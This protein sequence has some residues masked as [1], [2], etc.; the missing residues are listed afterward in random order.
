MARPRKKAVRPEYQPEPPKVDPEIGENIKRQVLETL[1]KPKDHD[2]TIVN[3]A[4]SAFRVNVYREIEPEKVRITDSFYIRTDEEG[5]I[6]SS[7]PPLSRR[8]DGVA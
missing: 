4:G 7:N 6:V 1:G 8:Y 2:Q 3:R 5:K